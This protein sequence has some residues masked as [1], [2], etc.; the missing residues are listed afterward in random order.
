[1]ALDEVCAGAM[2]VGEEGRVFCEHYVWLRVS[3][4]RMKGEDCVGLTWEVSEELTMGT[5]RKQTDLESRRDGEKR[6]LTK[7]KRGYCS[8]ITRSDGIVLPLSR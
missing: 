2:A 7:G 4:S 3:G 6:R 1:M 8:Q 5:R